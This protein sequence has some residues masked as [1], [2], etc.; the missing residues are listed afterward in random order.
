LIELDDCVERCN[1]RGP[2]DERCRKIAVARFH[3]LDWDA[4]TKKVLDSSL[5]YCEDHL[6]GGWVNDAH[7][8]MM[9]LVRVGPTD[10]GS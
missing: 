7:V 6:L 1:R 10:A 3:L 4:E 2:H 9:G 8:W 5:A